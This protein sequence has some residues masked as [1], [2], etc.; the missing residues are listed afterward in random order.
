MV[1]A[2]KAA[3]AAHGGDLAHLGHGGQATGQLADDLFLVAAQLVDVD[4]RRAKVHT[5]RGHVAHLV[6][7]RGHVQQRLGRNAA[8]IQAD[9]AQ[10]GVALHDHHLQ[11]QVRSAEGGRVA[12]WA[13]A[14]HQ[15]V[16]VEVGTCHRSWPRVQGLALSLDAGA[17]VLGA[18]AQVLRG[19]WA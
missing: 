12:A 2:D 5:Q 1:G 19:G 3:V 9:A 6:H 10:R 14:E 18:A 11:P 13:T 8:H 7:H 4:H 17:T 16:A 15:H